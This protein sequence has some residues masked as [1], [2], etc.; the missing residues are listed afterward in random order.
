MTIKRLGV[1]SCC[2]THRQQDESLG[3]EGR[4][5]RERLYNRIFPKLPVYALECACVKCLRW[6]IHEGKSQREKA[7]CVLS[8]VPT[9][10]RHNCNG[11]KGGLH[12]GV[13]EMKPRRD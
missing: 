1:S 10:N 4:E 8:A 5:E 3:R 11:N 9:K 6:H 12:A 7:F 13:L 2:N